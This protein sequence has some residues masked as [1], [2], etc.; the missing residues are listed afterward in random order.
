MKDMIENNTKISLTA[1]MAEEMIES[2]QFE[3]IGDDIKCIWCLMTIDCQDCKYE[4]SACLKF[5]NN[6]SI[7]KS[8]QYLSCLVQE[9]LQN[10]LQN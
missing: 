7:A 5:I 10:F 2:G 1:E 3:I 8:N 4:P 9:I 6:S